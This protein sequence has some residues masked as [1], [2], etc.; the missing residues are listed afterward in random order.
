MW[1]AVKE[2]DMKPSCRKCGTIIVHKVIDLGYASGSDLGRPAGAKG[3]DEFAI[4]TYCPT[5]ESPA[6]PDAHGDFGRVAP[7]C[8]SCGKPATIWSDCGDICEDSTGV[9]YRPGGCDTSIYVCDKP[10][11]KEAA[12]ANVLA[13]FESDYG[14]GE[15][16]GD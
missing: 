6:I 13:Q 11:C 8:V 7:S 1:Y 5:C 10:G 16:F 14:D 15:G 4:G 12:I 3:R 2:S 9:F